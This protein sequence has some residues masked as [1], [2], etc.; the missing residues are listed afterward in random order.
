MVQPC[1]SLAFGCAPR[2]FSEGR[3]EHQCDYINRWN[4]ALLMPK[5][6]QI[7]Y[8]FKHCQLLWVYWTYIR[9]NFISLVCPRA[10][11]EVFSNE[12]LYVILW[13][14]LIFTG[15]DIR[16][17]QVRQKTQHYKT[18]Y[19][20]T[21]SCIS[22]MCWFT[23]LYVDHLSIIFRKQGWLSILKKLFEHFVTQGRGKLTCVESFEIFV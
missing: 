19:F 14:N 12:L 5:N 22:K 20:T 9:R 13:N 17:A 23:K 7:K 3:F 2:A 21:L 6:T 4:L 10:K 16:W 15:L 1:V 8:F 18:M 11:E